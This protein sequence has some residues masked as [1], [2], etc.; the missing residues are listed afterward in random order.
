MSRDRFIR[1]EPP[2][3][4]PP[5]TPITTIVVPEG[6]LPIPVS[7]TAIAS[8]LGKIC[9]EANESLFIGLTDL[10]QAIADFFIPDVWPL[11]ELEAFFNNVFDDLQENLKPF[12]YNQGV[13]MGNQ[14]EG[15]IEDWIKSKFDIAKNEI[16]ALRD[17]ALGE[18]NT[19]KNELLEHTQKIQ[20]LIERVGKLEGQSGILGE[21]G[22]IF[23]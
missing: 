17:Q 22:G 23:K 19:A 1:R 4:T 5:P 13:A 3:P 10:F 20:D 18:I 6:G 11:S 15:K 16:E 7:K 9:G 21:L 8:M 12:A 14:I 2:P